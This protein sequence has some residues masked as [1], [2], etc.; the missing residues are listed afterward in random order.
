MRTEPATPSRLRDVAVRA[1]VSVGLASRILNE[2]PGVRA[3]DETRERVRRAASELRYR[4][5]APARALRAR[6]ANSVGVVLGDLANPLNAE[7]LRGIE[8]EARKRSLTV[9][10]GRAEALTPDTVDE[11]F[12]RQ[13]VD[14]LVISGRPD[15]PTAEVDAVVG[16][17]PAVLVHAGLDGRPGSV[18]G[19]DAAA[20]ALAVTHLRERDHERIALVTG[21]PF[22]TMASLR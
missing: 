16:P 20:M 6:R 14:G 19:D 10:L 17:R 3:S 9:L 8:V 21:A 22:L 11:L 13:V 7:L 2:R 5:H 15:R 4:P 18:R 1:G 12:D